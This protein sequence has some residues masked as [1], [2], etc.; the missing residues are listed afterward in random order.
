MPKLAQEVRDRMENQHKTRERILASIPQYEHHFSCRLCGKAINVQEGKD[1]SA[2]LHRHEKRHPEYEDFYKKEV[3]L[4]ET[5]AALH[6]HDCESGQ[7][8]CICGCANYMGCKTVLG[9]LCSACH[10]QHVR[11][12]EKHELKGKQIEQSRPKSDHQPKTENGRDDENSPNA[13]IY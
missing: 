12:N 7:C 6:D 13:R 11:G 2:A 10:I 9:A 5:F 8:E 1:H 4:K 3:S